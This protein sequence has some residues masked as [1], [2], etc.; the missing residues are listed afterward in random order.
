MD[1]ES[2]RGLAARLPRVGHRLPR[3]HPGR[4]LAGLLGGPQQPGPGPTTPRPTS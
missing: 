4:G 3:L 1:A 2:A